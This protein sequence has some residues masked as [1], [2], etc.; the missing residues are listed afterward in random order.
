MNRFFI[1]TLLLLA[2]GPFDSPV[3]T[4]D[5][6][7]A[8]FAEW[9]DGAERPTTSKRGPAHVVWTP[10]GQIEWQGLKYG[11]SKNPGLRHLR[12]GFKAPVRVGSV[13]VRGGGRLSVLKPDAAYPG[14]LSKDDPGTA[15]ER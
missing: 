13:L 5:L 10:G 1:L 8:T 9:V 14:D 4:G 3:A 7:P 2:A 11:E 15:A 12:V 6:D